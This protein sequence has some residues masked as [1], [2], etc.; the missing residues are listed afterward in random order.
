M[1]ALTLL[2]VSPL[3]PYPSTLALTHTSRPVSARS[4]YTWLTYGDF[5]RRLLPFAAGLRALV[6]PRAYVGIL[7]RNS[8]ASQHSL[9][10]TLTLPHTHTPLAIAPALFCL[11]VVSHFCV[12]NLL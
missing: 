2:G 9:T 11:V 1:S 6:P 10:L 5:L 4:G 8:G 7:G 3:L 12:L